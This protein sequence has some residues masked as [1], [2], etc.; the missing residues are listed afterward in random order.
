MKD[1][2]ASELFAAGK[3]LLPIV[4]EGGALFFVNDRIDVALALGADGVHLGPDD[5]PV[6][7]ARRA[8]GDRLVIGASTDEV[9]TARALVQAGAD[10]IGC[11][12]V[13]ETSTKPDAGY[14][15]GLEGLDGV[16]KAVSVPVVGIGGISVGR[17]RQV[18]S[19]RAAG[20]A[21][22]GAAMAATD[23]AGVIRGLLEP[24]G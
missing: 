12:T 18:A 16:A 24:W 14:V 4:R 10:Y 9:S 17:S 8:I 2:S 21:V 3:E 23:V 19:T 5:V 15:I 20:V 22:V 6:E 1:A 7:A 11:G 13:Y